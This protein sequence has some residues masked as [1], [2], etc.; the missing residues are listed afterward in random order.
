[1]E[2][3]RRSRAK[4]RAP[5]TDHACHSCDCSRREPTSLPCSHSRTV[6][7]TWYGAVFLHALTA[8]LSDTEI[9][10]HQLFEMPRWNAPPAATFGDIKYP[11]KRCPVLSILRSN[12]LA[13]ET[14]RTLL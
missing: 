6:L 4:L 2:V 12:L 13:Q 10:G 14:T 11:C 5:L 8:V 1:M 9:Y 3:S 7:R